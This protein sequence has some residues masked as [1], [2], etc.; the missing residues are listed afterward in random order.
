V[1]DVRRIAELRLAHPGVSATHFLSPAAGYRRSAA[2]HRELDDR[3]VEPEA[4]GGG[5]EELAAI[6]QVSPS[7]LLIQ[8]SRI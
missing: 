4:I 3:S 2:D 5:I 8:W 6:H 1:E 7:S